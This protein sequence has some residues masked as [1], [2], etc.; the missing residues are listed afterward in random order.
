MRKITWVL[1]QLNILK[2]ILNH[3]Y[4]CV[5]TCVC[6]QG[7]HGTWKKR[8]WKPLALSLVP[9]ACR[10]W[11]HVIRIG[12]KHL[13]PL[14]RFSRPFCH[15]LNFSIQITVSH[16]RIFLCAYLF[17]CAPPPHRLHLPSQ[18]LPFPPP[19]Y[20]VQSLSFI[21]FPFPL[22]YPLSLQ[23]TLSSFITYRHTKIRIKGFHMKINKHEVV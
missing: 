20:Y 12:K 13:Y 10:D 18:S 6:T 21:S 16:Q 14:S 11:T 7:P 23:W 8:T 9:V 2:I 4:L 19:L 15:H 3:I 17:A 22:R 1:R 5:C